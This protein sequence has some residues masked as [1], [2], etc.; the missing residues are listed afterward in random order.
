MLNDWNDNLHLLLVLYKYISTTPPNGYEMTFTHFYFSC[1]EA[2]IL[3]NKNG[4]GCKGTHGAVR[5]LIPTEMFSPS[6]SPWAIKIMLKTGWRIWNV[7]IFGLTSAP[8]ET[9]AWGF[10]KFA[11]SLAQISYVDWNIRWIRLCGSYFPIQTPT[12]T[13]YT[14][15]LRLSLLSLKSCKV[16]EKIHHTPLLI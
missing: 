2:K 5:F 3:P 16:K 10:L 8:Y 11:N 14:Q 13:L 6:L 7:Y 9:R 4:R 12:S 15:T 1:R